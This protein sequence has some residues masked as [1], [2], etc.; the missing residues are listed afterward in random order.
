MGIMFA[1]KRLTPTT[2]SRVASNPCPNDGDD[3]EDPSARV[4]EHWKSGS[5]EDRLVAAEALVS[6]A[7]GVFLP[8]RGDY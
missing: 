3:E 6:V 4:A 7:H 8:G 1:T 5:I 2:T